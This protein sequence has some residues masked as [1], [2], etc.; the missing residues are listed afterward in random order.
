MSK[1]TGARMKRIG[2]KTAD[3]ILLDGGMGQEL[4]RRGIQGNEMLWSANALLSD[5]D[6][7]RDIHLEFINAGAQVITTNTYSTKP[8]RLAR[9]G[10]GEYT[11]SLNRIA[12]EMAQDARDRSGKA[13]VKIAASIPPQYSYRPDIEIDFEQTVSEYEE[14]VEI[15]DPYVDL[16]L[17]ETMTDA[18]EALAATTACSSTGKPVWCAWTFKD[19]GSG[20]LRSE[21][22]VDATIAE[23][24]DVKIDAFMANCSAPES[25]GEVIR[26]MHKIFDNDSERGQNGTP[27]IGGYA[28]GFTPIP[29]K[30][31][32]GN[33][34]ELGVRRQ[35]T[36][37]V[38]ADFVMGWIADGA[39]IVGGCCEISPAHIRKIHE[40]LGRD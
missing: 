19:D 23:M 26:Q 32:P 2:M 39:Q 3:V 11:V 7:V 20:L 30:W 5:A 29:P 38:Y 28:N 9:V 24:A 6:V 10:M 17:C 34:A 36:P 35:L 1:R 31:K 15:L 14:M 33:I 16:Y 4:Y 22:R 12:C 37:D 8:G 25:V 21:D 40:R 13:D 27:M 18:R